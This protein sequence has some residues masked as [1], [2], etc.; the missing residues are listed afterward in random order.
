VRDR[1]GS[2]SGRTPCYLDDDD[3]DDDD[4]EDDDDDADM[5]FEDRGNLF[6]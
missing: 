5:Y 6:F 2:A 4:D 1:I 3:D